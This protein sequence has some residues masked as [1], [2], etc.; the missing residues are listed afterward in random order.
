[1]QKALNKVQELKDSASLIGDNFLIAADDLKTLS[2]S[3]PG[4]LEAY[5]GM[6]NGMIELD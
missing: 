1:L 3:F 4:V 2:E 6:S 5:K